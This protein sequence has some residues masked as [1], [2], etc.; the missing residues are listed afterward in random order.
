MLAVCAY[1]K[2]KPGVVVNLSPLL[3]DEKHALGSWIQRKT[4]PV[5]LLQSRTRV[6]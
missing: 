5:V 4:A 2:G 1:T 3:K 6:S